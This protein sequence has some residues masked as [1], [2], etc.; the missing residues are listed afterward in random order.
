MRSVR[1]TL[2]PHDCILG[3]GKS[4]I[5]RTRINIDGVLYTTA[6]GNPCSISVDP[7]EKKPLFHFFPGT[8]ILSLATAGC[9]LRCLNCQ[10][11]T[12]S[13]ISP[14]ETD[15]YFLLPDAVVEEALKRSVPAIAF[16]YTE[17]TVFYEYMLQI[18]QSAKKRGVKTAM[19]SNGYINEKPLKEL[20]RSLDAA[21][22]DLKCFD[23]KIYRT[24]TGGSLDPVLNSLKILHES[25]VWLEITNLLIPGMTDSPEMIEKMCR[26]LVDNGFS[27][28]PIHFSRF[29]PT[30][31]LKDLPPTP[32]STLKEAQQIAKNAGVKFVYIGNSPSLAGESTICPACGRVVIERNGYIVIQNNILNGSCSSCKEKIAGVWE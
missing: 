19:V 11:W 6:F 28:N 10:N 18:A 4:G 7:I 9:N 24:L 8:E 2:C 13:Q 32:E 3:D 14:S 27:D 17:P 25:G 21:N 26:W 1:C 30:F 15:N 5:C 12:I 20:S 29:F 31:I 23:D 22:I 16:T